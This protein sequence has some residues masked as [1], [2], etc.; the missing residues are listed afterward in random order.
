MWER[1]AHIHSSKQMGGVCGA[2]NLGRVAISRICPEKPGK[3]E[4]MAS[5]DDE[6]LC[7]APGPL[8]K[9]G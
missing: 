1:T 2:E 8:A 4:R 3:R 9:R 6:D 5:V 7:A